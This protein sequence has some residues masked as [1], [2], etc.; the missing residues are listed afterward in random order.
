[1]NNAKLV[2]ILDSADDLLIH[3]GSLV[4]LKSPILHDVLEQLA[5]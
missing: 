5:T 3:L 2:N 4:L 1:M